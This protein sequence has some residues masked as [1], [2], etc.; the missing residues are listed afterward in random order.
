MV[1]FIGLGKFLGEFLFNVGLEVFESLLKV[2]NLLSVVCSVLFD[3]V[4]E[5]LHFF[6]QVEYF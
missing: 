5:G 3:N 2:F 4:I 1:L 6:F